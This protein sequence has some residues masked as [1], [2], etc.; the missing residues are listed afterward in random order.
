MNYIMYL[1]NVSVFGR[2]INKSSRQAPTSYSLHSTMNCCGLRSTLYYPA[3]K[4]KHLRC[5]LPGKSWTW[6]PSDG[7]AGYFEWENLNCYHLSPQGGRCPYYSTVVAQLWPSS[8]P[9]QAAYNKEV[10]WASYCPSQA[11]LM[12]LFLWLTRTVPVKTTI[13]EISRF[14]CHNKTTCT[15]TKQVLAHH[16][17]VYCGREWWIHWFVLWRYLQH[18]QCCLQCSLQKTTWL[19][20]TFDKLYMAWLKRT[21]YVCNTV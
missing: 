21:T 18:L 13:I 14:A 20:I 9:Q 5:V 2:K 4:V 19:S 11:T 3:K 16:W 12:N 8:G 17:H 1:G 7:T 15:I 6:I 10:Y